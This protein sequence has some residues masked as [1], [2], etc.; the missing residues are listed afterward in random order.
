MSHVILQRQTLKIKTDVLIIGAGLAGILSAI[1]AAEAGAEV[2]LV[3][4]GAICSGSSFYPGTWGFGLVGPENKADEKDLADTIMQ[5]GCQMP[6]RKLVE[7]FVSHINESISYLEQMGVPL[8]KADNPKEREFIPCFDHKTRSW[9]GIV[10]EEAKPVFQARL[11]ELGVQTLPHTE[12]TELRFEQEAESGF[13]S[14]PRRVTGAVA[15]KDQR[16]LVEFR[17]RS[18]IIASG[19]LGGL[20]RYRLNPGDVT[21]MGQYLALT[22]GAKLVN[23]EFMQ[24]MPGFISPAYGTVFNEKIF[25]YTCSPAYDGW[26][27]KERQELLELRSGHGPYSSRLESGRVDEAL[28]AAWAKEPEGVVVSYAPEL[29]NHQPEFVKTYFEWLEREKRL[30][31]DD[32]VRLGIFAHASNGG[33]QID[34]NGFTGIPGLYACGEVTGGMHGADRL[35]GLSTANGLVFGRAAGTAAAKAAQAVADSETK[36]PSVSTVAPTP[37]FTQAAEQ[38][39][40]IQTVKAVRM[41]LKTRMSACAMIGRSEARCAEMLDWLSESKKRWC[42]EVAMGENLNLYLE[43]CRLR[44]EIMMAICMIYAIRLRKESRGSHHRDDYPAENTELA[45]QIIVDMENVT[46]G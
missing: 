7:F 30:T 16:E 15:V 24:M 26:E 33:I 36:K 5:V 3:S 10:K 40:D 23:L 22:A 35:G 20:Y 37:A 11:K 21:G 17:C 38:A 18:L 19:G 45:Y 25:R 39:E 28:T 2:T 41:E 31:V 8:K 1:S 6:D 44:S 4:S 34:E 13:P 14:A 9:H 42:S 46:V 27:E 32:P 29:K 43:Q 12:V